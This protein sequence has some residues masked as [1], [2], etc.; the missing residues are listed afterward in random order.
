MEN[1]VIDSDIL[2]DNNRGLEKSKDFLIKLADEGHNV[3]ISAASI[4]E[5]YSA[6]SALKLGS[7]MAIDELVEKFD[8]IELDLYIG[9]GAGFLRAKYGVG[10]ADSII[11]ASSISRK[12]ILLTRNLKHFERVNDLKDKKPY[13]I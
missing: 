7:K 11:A 6:K 9:K 3:L 8:V 12:A 5:L 1:Y 4:V 2:I 13:K 10:F